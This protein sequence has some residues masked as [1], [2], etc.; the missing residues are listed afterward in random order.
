[1]AQKLYDA[2]SVHGWVYLKDFGINQGEVNE[3]FAIVSCCLLG[4]SLFRCLMVKE[5]E[6]F[7]NHLE[8]K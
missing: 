5:L 6:Y 2:F 8:V 1:M 3:L 7:D 4:T